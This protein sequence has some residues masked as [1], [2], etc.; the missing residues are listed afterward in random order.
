MPEESPQRRVDRLLD[1]LEEATDRHDWD[2]VRRLT[3]QVLECGPSGASA[4]RLMQLSATADAGER[5][6]VLARVWRTRGD[7]SLDPWETRDYLLRWYGSEIRAEGLLAYWPLVAPRARAAVLR[8]V[9]SGLDWTWRFHAPLV[10]CFRETGYLG[11]QPPPVEPVTVYRGVSN[12]R[13]RRGL[14][15]AA[16]LETARAFGATLRQA[17]TSGG[18]TGYVYRVT[19]PPSAVL[20]RLDDRDEARPGAPP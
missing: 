14:S 19:A 16:S 11:E 5:D 13:H 10:R 7:E 9:W 4:I 15:W 8:E 20:A 2:E 12:K 17:L 6:D 1:Q 3:R 18:D